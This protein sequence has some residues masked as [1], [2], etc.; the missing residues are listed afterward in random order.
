M[1]EL[2]KTIAIQTMT[3]RHPALRCGFKILDTRPYMEEYNP[4]TACPVIRILSK[5]ENGSLDSQMI[6]NAVRQPFD[7]QNESPVRW[8]VVEQPF[9]KIQLYLVAHH[10]AVDG[11]SMSLLSTELLELFRGEPLE[12]TDAPTRFSQMHLFEVRLL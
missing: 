12:S 3:E 4:A 9:S 8:V 6:K 5:P 7:L 2:I 1:Q 11:T 10:I